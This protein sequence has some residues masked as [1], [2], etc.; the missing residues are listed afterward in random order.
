MLN[1]LIV[2]F[3][4]LTS[5]S[6][7][8]VKEVA[9]AVAYIHGFKNKAISGKVTFVQDDKGFVH[10]TGEITGLEPNHIYAIHIHKYGDCSSPKASA[11]HF[12]P[13]VSG[14]HGSP[15][16]PIGTHHSGDLP[17][18]KTDERGVARINFKTKAVT[19]VPSPF[20]VLG[21]AVVIHERADDYKSQPAGN[22]GTRI[23]C[24]VI[25]LIKE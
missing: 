16:D 18:I 25:G 20:S 21:R 10:I 7:S 3:V 17:N 4:I 9:K 2:M 1:R 5:I 12:D 15:S 11:G 14:R 23:A 6:L 19:V 13:F 22:A 8:Q 24:G